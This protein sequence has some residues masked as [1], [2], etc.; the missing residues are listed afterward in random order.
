MNPVPLFL[1]IVSLPL[2]LGG[3]GEKNNATDEAK[4]AE[5]RHRLIKS[6]NSYGK[7]EVANTPHEIGRKNLE[8]RQGKG[9]MEGSEIPY[10]GK[11]FELH[12][13][14]Q[15]S[16][17]MTFRQG[18]VDGPFVNYYDN[19]KKKDEGSIKNNKIIGI[20]TQWYESGQKYA[21]VNWKDG[22]EDGSWILWHENGCKQREASYRNGKEDGLWTD[23]HNNGTK[24]FERYF[25]NGEILTT[26]LKMWNSKGKRVYSKKEALK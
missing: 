25:R 4:S 18:E 16:V 23:Y 3:C 12:S 5:E 10:T 8:E 24:K 13:N 2:L 1:I 11:V 21:E 7:K 22:I 20:H 26:S 14:G 17:E 9:F 6:E 19:G 15:R